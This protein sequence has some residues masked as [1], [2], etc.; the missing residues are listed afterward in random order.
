MALP[1]DL[2]PTLQVLTNRRPL[3]VD[4]AVVGG[5]PHADILDDHVSAKDTLE[6]EPA[7]RQARRG[8]RGAGTLAASI[9]QAKGQ[10]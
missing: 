8:K 4:H 7:A 3:I 5:I 9:K 2:Q 1:R 6:S 10:A